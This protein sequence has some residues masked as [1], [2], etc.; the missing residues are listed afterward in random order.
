MAKSFEVL[1]TPYRDHRYRRPVSQVRQ[2][3]DVMFLTCCCLLCFHECCSWFS[4]QDRLLFS[5]CPNLYN[6]PSFQNIKILSYWM[7][8][9]L[10]PCPLSTMCHFLG[11]TNASLRYIL[12]SH[13]PLP[14]PEISSN[15]G[16]SRVNIWASEAHHHP[17]TTLGLVGSMHYE[18]SL[19]D[20]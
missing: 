5:S 13:S 10:G 6:N 4:L 18:S 11:N 7:S 3:D 9:H 2:V 17:G 12:S 20:A 14:P 1:I 15:S 16:N 19:L 8:D